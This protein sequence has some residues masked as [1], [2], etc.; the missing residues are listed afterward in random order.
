MVDRQ[1]GKLW[2]LWEADSDEWCYIFFFKQQQCKGL[3]V[4]SDIW[5]FISNAV[6][7][8]VQLTSLCKQGKGL[9]LK[10]NTPGKPQGIF[11]SRP[12]PV[13]SNKL[14][15]NNHPRVNSAYMT[16]HDMI[17]NK[18]FKNKVCN[19]SI[20]LCKNKIWETYIYQC[21]FV[22]F[23]SWPCSNTVTCPVL[24]AMHLA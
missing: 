5:L 20:P 9:E 22:F 18:R 13:G 15:K 7:S 4:K 2:E 10:I 1:S 23:C 6:R 8:Y 24:A 21:F 3:Y 16:W 19:R 12:F 17:N 11:M 14:P